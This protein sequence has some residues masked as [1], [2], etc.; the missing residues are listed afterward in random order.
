ML[1]HIAV[2]LIFLSLLMSGCANKDFRLF[3]EDS[4]TQNGD[5]KAVKIVS[6]EEYRE[7]IEYEW[8]IVKGDR[9][10]IAVFNQ[11]AS[12][13]GGQLESILGTSNMTQQFNNRDGTEGLLIP[14]K[15]NVHLPLIGNVKVA[16]L[17][18]NEAAEKLTE[19]YKKFLRNPYVMVK[20]QNQRL[21]VLGEVNDPG[22]VQVTAGT[23]T[24]FEALAQS[25][26]VTDDGLRTNIRIIRGDLRNPTMREVDLTDMGAIRVASLMLRPN[27][28]VY[29]QPRNMKAYNIAFEEQTPFFQMLNTM[30]S[31]FVSFRNI[32]DGYKL[33]F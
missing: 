25:G 16:G 3:E 2:V 11:S 8:K 30:M 31:P 28:I 5:S 21:F 13:K 15:G 29:V 10:Q 32:K 14:T 18:E 23:M 6:D 17:T 1:K 4:Q 26:D 9:I 24:L 19:K 27:D 22:V 33:H 20:I 7:E 12:S